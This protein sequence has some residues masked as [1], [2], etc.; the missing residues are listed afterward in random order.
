MISNQHI[1]SCITLGYLA[2]ILVV[3]NLPR[4]PPPSTDLLL[5]ALAGLVFLAI[6]RKWLAMP[7]LLLLFSG[8]LAASFT[9]NKARD[10]RADQVGNS[11]VGKIITVD[12]WVSSLPVVRASVIPSKQAET[13]QDARFLFQPLDYANLGL[14]K[15]LRISWY[16]NAPNLMAGDFLRLSLRLK[17]PRGRLN[18]TGFDFERWLFR[19]QIGALGSVAS[20][21]LIQPQQLSMQAKIKRASLKWRHQLAQKLTTAGADNSANANA[22]I[23]ALA[24][25][26]RSGIEPE[27]RD[28]FAR[29]GTA[30]LLAI[31]GLHI[32]LVASFGFM[33]G[34]LLF[35]LLA[36]ILPQLTE[37]LGKRRLALVPGMLFALSYATLAGW[38]LPTQRAVIML[39]VI[40]LGLSLRRKINPWAGWSLALLLVLMLDPMA[41]LDAGFWLSFTAVACLIL[42]LSGRQSRAKPWR[43]MLRAQWVV[44]LALLPLTVLL[45][46]RIPMASLFSNLLAIPLTGF[47]L[48]P[49]IMLAIVLVGLVPSVTGLILA[50]V[51]WLLDFLESFLTYLDRLIPAV[52]MPLA[53]I[54][55]YALA[56]M[57][58]L[59]VLM[60][61]LPRGLPVRWQGLVWLLPLFL[62]FYSSA[63]NALRVEMLDV[64]QGLA[65][66]LETADEVL[67]YDSGPGDGAGRDLVATVLQP[68]IAK[69]GK[70]LT[71]IVISHA[72]ND[73]AGG[74]HSLRSI[75]PQANYFLNRPV[76]DYAQLCNTKQAIAW[77]ENNEI[78]LAVLHPNPEL[79]YLGNDSS[80]VLALEVFGQQILL[81]GDIGQTIEQR[82]LRL[83]PDLRADILLVP[84]HG[85]R[86]SSAAEFII[87]LDPQFALLSTG[88]AN[89]FKLPAEQV[90]NRYINHGISLLNTSQCGAVRVDFRRRGV[91]PQLSFARD[92]RRAIWRK[93]NNDCW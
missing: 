19:Q 51:A 59:A 87:Q 41:P 68:A 45:F 36:R 33:L 85:S 8:L 61:L 77:P 71:T 30:H 54:P 90:V 92:Q 18:F 10:I 42:M 76:R 39:L 13:T 1:V 25:A 58:T 64:G 5:L 55:T 34:N 22:L 89:R 56:I 24:I 14:P 40:T 4:L 6:I 62:P 15:T 84:H 20:G 53:N 93:N 78:K 3:L 32:G 74:L 16:K 80:C 79:P 63:G 60:L 70:P 31:S 47:L 46:A 49:L 50:I 48:V 44:V 86:S 7:I 11:I 21:Q 83:H 37:R 91:A 26:D 35:P 81:T 9:L 28:L 72:D 52:E 2:G 57:A 27:L 17:P 12:G 43:S 23:R 73:H 88:F 29:S 65:V 75:Y 38:S 69:T 82:I 66:L 67:L